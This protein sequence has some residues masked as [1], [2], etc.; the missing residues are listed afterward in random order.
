MDCHRRI[1]VSK[2]NVRPYICSCLMCPL[3]YVCV[4]VHTVVLKFIRQLTSIQQ[5]QH[6][7]CGIAIVFCSEGGGSRWATIC[8]RMYL[9]C[10]AYV[11]VR[12]CVKVVFQ[13]IFVPSE[14]RCEPP[15]L[16]KLFIRICLLLCYIS[17]D[18]NEIDDPIHSVRHS[19]SWFAARLYSSS[20]IHVICFSFYFSS[21]FLSLNTQQASTEVHFHFIL[22]GGLNNYY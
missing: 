2:H 15:M 11:H 6:T 20:A 13:R 3:M 8:C 22:M 7:V 18:D 16:L 9:H 12:A 5:C 19:H 21:I 1:L 14:C 17:D 4:R 10:S